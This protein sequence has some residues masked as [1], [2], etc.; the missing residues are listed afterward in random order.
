LSKPSISQYFSHSTTGQSGRQ[1]GESAAFPAW[2]KEPFL[3]VSRYHDG[4]LTTSNSTGY[5][6]GMLGRFERMSYAVLLI[7]M[8]RKLQ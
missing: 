7:Y 8:A 6:A 4:W 1:T 2:Q 3:K 5:Q